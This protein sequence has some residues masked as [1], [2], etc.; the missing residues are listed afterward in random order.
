MTS[1]HHQ[2]WR[3]VLGKVCVREGMGW[4]SIGPLLS[5]RA[6]ILEPVWE[7]GFIGKLLALLA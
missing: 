7:A 1:H 3:R 4:E 2:Q 6:R 5:L